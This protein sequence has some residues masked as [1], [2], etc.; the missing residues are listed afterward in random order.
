VDLEAMLSIHDAGAPDWENNFSVCLG[1]NVFF[2]SH[3]NFMG[4]CRL[5]ILLSETAHPGDDIAF[6]Y[7]SKYN[8]TTNTAY[9]NGVAGPSAPSVG[10][11]SAET[12][13]LGARNTILSHFNKYE[14]FEVMIFD[15]ALSDAYRNVVET[16]L[17]SKYSLP[18]P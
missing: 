8:G 14:Y 13:T 17:R 10:K 18:T 6:I 7:G 2:G 12:I 11:F 16:Y 9:I 4:D 15:C 5:D 1:H 3:Q